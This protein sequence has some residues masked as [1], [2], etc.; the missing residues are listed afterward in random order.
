MSHFEVI[1]G[2]LAI[3]AEARIHEGEPGHVYLWVLQTT[4]AKGQ[5]VATQHYSHQM[6]TVPQLKWTRPTFADVID[7]PADGL[8]VHVLIARMPQGHDLEFLKEWL[9][10]TGVSVAGQRAQ[11]PL[12]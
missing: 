5:I 1:D 6:F 4:N 10:P 2:R 3:T 8:F 9:P 12:R 7:P 11:M